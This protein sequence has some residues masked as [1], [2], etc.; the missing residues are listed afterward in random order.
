ME[1]VADLVEPGV[2]QPTLPHTAAYGPA[3]GIQFAGTYFVMAA[4]MVKDEE[5][6][7]LGLAGKQHRIDDEQP[8]IRHRYPEIGE[9][10]IQRVA[11]LS[12]F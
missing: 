5:A 3:V 4:F 1:R 11:D 7:G 10:R 12:T 6:H 8:P 9:V 2:V